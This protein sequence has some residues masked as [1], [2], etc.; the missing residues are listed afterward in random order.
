MCVPRRKFTNGLFVTRE[1][2]L[3]G[4][5]LTGNRARRPAAALPAAG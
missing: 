1:G 3:L 4:L 2:T 5:S